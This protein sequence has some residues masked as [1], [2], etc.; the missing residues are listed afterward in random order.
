MAPGL[1]R[2][3]APLH[4]ST[5]PAKLVHQLR[6]HPAIPTRTTRPYPPGMIHVRIVSTYPPAFGLPEESFDLTLPLRDGFAST[7]ARRTS[8]SLMR[9][10]LTTCSR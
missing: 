7:P 2:G 10:G 1:L 6:S 9:S 8:T 4:G 5:E 3:E